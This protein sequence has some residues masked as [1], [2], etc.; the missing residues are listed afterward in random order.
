M[1][2]SKKDVL[3]APKIIG[4]FF[5]LVLVSTFIFRGDFTLKTLLIDGVISIPLIAMVSWFWEHKLSYQ[6]IESR[7]GTLFFTKKNIYTG[8]QSIE[9][10]TDH[11]DVKGGGDTIHLSIDIK[12]SGRKKTVCLMGC[13]DETS[14]HTISSV[15][16][17]IS[18][19]TGVSSINVS[20][21]FYV[22]YQEKFNKEFSLS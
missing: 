11:V 4:W 2:I 3:V 5:I 16:K 15:V 20:D 19:V 7:F 21:H 18:E 6:K 13:L 9:L 14:K 8:L 1:I 12:I 10:S 22:V 17:E